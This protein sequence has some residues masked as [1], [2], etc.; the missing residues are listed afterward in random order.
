MAHRL[1][2]TRGGPARQRGYA[3]IMVI[4][5]FAMMASYMIAN[6]LSRTGAEVNNDRDRN[7]LQAMQTAKAALIAYAASYA[8]GTDG[9]NDQPGGLPCP[10][11]DDAGTAGSCSATASTR[12]GRFPWKTFGTSE[13]RDASGQILWYALSANFRKAS[14]TTVINSDTQGTLTINNSAGNAIASNLVAVIIAPGA[15]LSGQNRSV[16]AVSN[17]LESTNA[18]GTD[19]FV[20]K[21]APDTWNNLTAREVVFN[22]SIMMITQADLMAVVEPAVAARIERDVKPGL[23]SQ[24]S[25]WGRLPFPALFNN[26]S[27]VG[28]GTSAT[29]TQDTYIGDATPTTEGLLPLTTLVNSWSGGT[30]T[31]VSGTGNLSSI[32]CATVASVGYRCT[33]NI[34]GAG[35]F[36]SISNL[37]VQMDAT[38]DRA[39]L[40]FTYKPTVASADTTLNNVTNNFVLPSFTVAAMT[41]AGAAPITYVGTIN[42]SCNFCS[43]TRTVRITFAD[44]VTRPIIS[45]TD[46]TN[47]WFIKNHWYR[48]TYYAVSPGYL[49]GGSGACAAGSTCLTVQNWPPSSNTTATD[50]TAILIFAG[51]ALSGARPSNILA[52]YLEGE[53]QTTGDRIFVNRTGTA[54]SAVTLNDRAIVISP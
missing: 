11:A 14:G 40:G 13:L 47:G 39:G 4:S 31:K 19:I 2:I 9:A 12:V 50:K 7:T 8:W 44:L 27:N 53:N 42:T 46:T 37:R 15:A 5:L 18:T 51:R 1:N 28:P 43:G 35:A 41:S 21:Q 45:S 23:T 48:Q 10:A 3:M 30:V 33:F 17:Y 29:R 32:V 25:D 20:T 49:P 22:D 38:A 52:S 34:T 54:G 24:L 16:N 36:T 26:A 6:G